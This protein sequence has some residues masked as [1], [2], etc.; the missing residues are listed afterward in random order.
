M[1][2]SSEVLKELLAEATAGPWTV[3]SSLFDDMAAVVVRDVDPLETVAEVR[4][5]KNSRLIALAPDLARDVIAL[6]AE[7]ARQPNISGYVR[8]FYELADMIGIPAQAAS[9]REVW[10]R[11][12]KP[13][14]LTALNNGEEP[15]GDKERRALAVEGDSDN[16]LRVAAANAILA[17]DKEQGI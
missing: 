4:A 8:A 9:P 5:Y 15:L 6:R 1:T 17:G 12:M 11:L 10:E 14:L 3:W 2:I 7:I 13:T 16:P